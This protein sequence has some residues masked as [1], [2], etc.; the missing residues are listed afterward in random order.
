MSNG[1]FIATVAAR[2]LRREFKAFFTLTNTQAIL[3]ADFLINY[4]LNLNLKLK[5]LS[6]PLKNLTA[7]LR[8]IQS[9]FF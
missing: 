6:N 1:Q 8:T 3:A 5:K 2:S 4:G 9:P 7:T